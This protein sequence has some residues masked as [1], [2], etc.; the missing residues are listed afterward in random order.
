MTTTRQGAARSVIVRGARWLLLAVVTGL[1]APAA[2]TAQP[3][4]IPET[5]GGD[6]W[7]RP[8]LTGDWFGL[9][10]EMGKRG[11]TLD[12]DM[13]N[14]LQGN[15]TGGRSTGVD[16]DGLVNYELNLDTGKLGL[17][18]GGFLRV[19][20][21]ST[22]GDTVNSDAGGTI[23]VNIVGILP[24]FDNST[25]S[26][27]MNL[28]Y[29]QFLAKWFGVY[30]GKVYTLGGDDNAFAHDFNTQFLNTA[31]NFN[32]T[33][34]FAPFSAY[35]GGLVFIPWEGALVTASLIDPSGTATNN[36][37]SEAFR[38]GFG[39]GAEGRVTIKP[40]GLVGHQ[41]VGFYWSDKTRVSL[42]QDPSNIATEFAKQR[43]PRLQD[44]GP[45]LRRMLER[46][47]PQLLVPVQPLNKKSSTWSIYYNFDQYLWS[48]AGAP[49]RGVGL[50]FRFGASDGN[51][52]PV[53]Y[54]YNVGFSFNGL[55]PGRP[56]DNIGLGWARTQFSGDFVPFLRQQLDLGLNVEDAVE[57]YYNAVLTPWLNLNVNLQVVKSALKKDLDSSGRLVNM[58]TAVVGG[59]RAYIRF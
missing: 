19:K 14:I 41:D 37:I 47:F 34:G 40:F 38:D 13:L 31:L 58:D 59:L 11:V 48:P 4:P 57:I 44:P 24:Q 21:F 18:P 35:G 52:N 32:T 51:P 25:T 55:V 23:P 9:R 39:V 16:Y 46:F 42:E 8:R 30:A 22:F 7:T 33:L 56:K 17:W 36:D 3:V 54:A 29:M 26:A 50:F 27:L 53:K 10:D 15:G 45:I 43:F 2:A 49:D 12:L 1:C 28:T 20:A 5:F 6:L